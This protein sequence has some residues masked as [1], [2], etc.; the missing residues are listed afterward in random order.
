MEAKFK[1]LGFLYTACHDLSLITTDL[2]PSCQPIHECSVVLWTRCYAFGGIKIHLKHHVPGEAFPAPETLAQRCV[3]TDLSTRLAPWGPGQVSGSSVEANLPG[4]HRTW[5]Q[6]VKVT[7]EPPQPCLHLLGLHAV[8][9][10]PSTPEDSW[11]SS[12]RS[13]IPLGNKILF[14]AYQTVT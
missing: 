8:A 10:L 6:R 4:D 13:V 11:D 3:I 12:V 7:R 14:P 5:V 1:F 9:L 2:S